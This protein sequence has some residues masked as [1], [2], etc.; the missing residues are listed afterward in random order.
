M[1]LAGKPKNEIMDMPLYWIRH[2]QHLKFNME[3]NKEIQFLTLKYYQ[4][5]INEERAISGAISLKKTISPKRI[6]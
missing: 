1:L 3:L 4:G 5:K 2:P 6:V